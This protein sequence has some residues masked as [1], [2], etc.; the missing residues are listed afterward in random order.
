MNADDAVEDRPKSEF[1]NANLDNLARCGTMSVV[2]LGI[3][4]YGTYRIVVNDEDELN[5]TLREIN[6]S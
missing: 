5:L 1:Q 4:F 6:C 2:Q 3:E